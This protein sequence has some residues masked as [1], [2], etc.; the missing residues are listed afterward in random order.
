MHSESKIHLIY[1]WVEQA[2]HL[3]IFCQEIGS[4][5]FAEYYF[6]LQKKALHFLITWI[7]KP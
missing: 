6:N 2:Q 5:Y 7:L 3:L 4:E 1:I